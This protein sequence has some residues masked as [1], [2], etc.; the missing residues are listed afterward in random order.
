M[1][2]VMQADAEQSDLDHVIARVERLGLRPHV[3]VGTE[4][5]VVAVVGDERNAQL[6]GPGPGGAPR[7]P[8]QPP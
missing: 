3:I 7:T 8:G 1:I 4:R 6:S 5:T 2:I